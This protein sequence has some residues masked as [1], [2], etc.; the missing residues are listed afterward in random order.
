MVAWDTC[1]AVIR[2]YFIQQST[3]Q[4]RKREKNKADLL[5]EIKKKEKELTKDLSNE[6]ISKEIKLLRAEYSS[7]LEQEIDCNLNILKSRN[8]ENANKP[9]K[10]LAW[11]IKKRQIKRLINRLKIGE[12][13]TDDPKKIRQDFVEYYRKLY[14]KGKERLEDIEQYLK[15]HKIPGI[16]EAQRETLNAPITMIEIKNAIKN[17]KSGKL[18]GPDGIPAEVSKKLEEILSP[19]LNEV[20]KDTLI[21]GK[22]PAPWNEA[23]VILLPK[24]GSDLEITANYRPISL[25]NC[26]Y[27]IYAGT[28]AG[29]L[30]HVLKDIIHPNWAAFLPKHQIPKNTRNI[31]NL[32]ENL[33]FKNEKQAAMMLIDARRRLITSHGA[34]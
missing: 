16:T 30:K 5:E 17:A 10:L 31:I 27:K 20:I 3:I 6:E 32:L 33:E 14:K 34:L 25:L 1:K 22:T 21:E 19:P 13:T 9:G 8:F 12:T 11:Q 24:K 28:L 2:G 29:R 23:Y 15:F 4:K 26:D 7:I 18:P